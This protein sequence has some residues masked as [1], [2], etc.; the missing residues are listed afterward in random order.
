MQEQCVGARNKSP[1]LLQ[2]TREHDATDKRLCRFIYSAHP[3]ALQLK[4]LSSVLLFNFNC[5]AIIIALKFRILCRFLFHS[6]PSVA[7]SRAEGAGTA[8]FH[9][10]G[11]F[12][13]Y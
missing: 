12:T 11:T 8:T 6:T 2:G 4:F 5:G 1:S 7:A 13:R 9:P 3:I 10:K